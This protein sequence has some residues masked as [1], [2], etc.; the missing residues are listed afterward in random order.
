MDD[1]AL[2]I[3]DFEIALIEEDVVGENEMTSG[4]ELF[5]YKPE[6]P[7]FELPTF[8]LDSVY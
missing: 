2:E 4:E 7:T 8:E 1:F 5:S 6:M 3:P